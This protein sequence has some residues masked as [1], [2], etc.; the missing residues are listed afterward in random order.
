MQHFIFPSLEANDLV[1]I[2]KQSIDPQFDFASA[3]VDMERQFLNM[4]K[5]TIPV[6]HQSR[7]LSNIRYEFNKI[8][9]LC[10]GI[11]LLSEFPEK[12][13]KSISSFPIQLAEYIQNEAAF[14]NQKS[15]LQ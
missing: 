6:L 9:S 4:A 10:K 7:V 2:A 1:T 11:Q 15:A 13:R 8:E 5:S 3:L 12:T 14:Y